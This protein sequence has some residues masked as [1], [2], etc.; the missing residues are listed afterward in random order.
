MQVRILLLFLAGYFA[1]VKAQANFVCPAPNG[2]FPDFAST[3]CTM[4]WRCNNCLPVRDRC[5]EGQQFDYA[6]TLCDADANVFCNDQRRNF[7][8]QPGAWQ[9]QPNNGGGAGIRNNFNP[10]VPGQGGRGVV[11]NLPPNIPQL[12]VQQCTLIQNQM[13]QFF[14]QMIQAMTNN[15][16]PGPQCVLPIIAVQC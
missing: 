8:P 16:C 4:F 7:Q 14:T 3:G 15:Q 10:V 5:A 11:I 9:C 6:R 2:I 12:N 1:Q 13:N